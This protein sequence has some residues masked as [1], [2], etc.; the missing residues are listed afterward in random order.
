MKTTNESWTRSESL[1]IISPVD[2]DDGPNSQRTNW[3]DLPAHRDEGQVE[4]DVNR[5]F[6]YYPLGAKDIFLLFMSVPNPSI[7]HGWD[8]EFW[9]A[10][11]WA[12]FWLR[13]YVEDFSE[14][15]TSDKEHLRTLLQDTIVG[16]LRRYPAL[17][18]F[19]GYHDVVS[20]F[21]LTFVDIKNPDPSIK[22]NTSPESHI[23]CADA[24]VSLLDRVMARFT[25]H[26]IRDSMTS[27]LD[28]IMGYLR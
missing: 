18:Y 19:Q 6:V 9:L 22:D 1:T 12:K 17:S 14:I 11:L 25:L 23:S 26:R 13:L 8:H 20:I 5:S 16:I 21:L 7:D 27:N 3:T 2:R 15:E 10:T 28:P 4:L 24:Q